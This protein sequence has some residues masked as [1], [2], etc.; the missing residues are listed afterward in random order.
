MPAAPQ[1]PSA[2]DISDLREQLMLLSTRASAAQ[3]TIHGMQAHQ[4]RSGLGMRQDI[5]SGME[6]I[7]W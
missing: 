5:V 6:R 1:T 4:N 2:S 3:Q 7:S